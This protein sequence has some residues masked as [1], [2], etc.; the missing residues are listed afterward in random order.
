MEE[1]VGSIG[2]RIRDYQPGDEPGTYFVCL[3]TGD[4]GKD[5]E[6]FFRD[7]PDALGRIYTAPYLQFAPELALILEDDQGICGYA[8]AALDSHAFFARYEQEW[9]GQLCEQF[10]APAGDPSQWTRLEEVYHLY[11]SPD[12]FCPEPYDEYPSHLHIDLLPR[13]QGQGHGRRLIEQLLDRLVAGGSP[14]VHLGMSA[15]NDA[16]YGFY[17]SLGFQELVRHEDAI[18]MG[19]RLTPDTGISEVR[20][21]VK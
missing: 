13:A 12:Y 21:N 3:K 18:Y 14:G 10:A 15:I 17:R 20:N 5:G 4:H 6:P 1:I 8:L 9:R 11:H 2:A 16:A 19:M 7:D